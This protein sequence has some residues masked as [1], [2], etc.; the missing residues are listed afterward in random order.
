MMIKKIIYLDSGPMVKN[1]FLKHGNEKRWKV[2]TFTL[3]PYVDG[4]G[5]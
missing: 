1:L 2:Q 3:A 4:L 5:V